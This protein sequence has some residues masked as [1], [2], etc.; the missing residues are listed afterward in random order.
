MSEAELPKAIETA[1][2]E[3]VET[4]AEPAQGKRASNGLAWLALLIAA[5]SAGAVSWQYWQ[6]QQVTQTVSADNAQVLE[7]QQ[8]LTAL[9]S[10]QHK[11]QQQI[12]QLQAKTADE[13]ELQQALTSVQGQQQR[14]AQQLD[15]LQNDG[16]N[17]LRLAEA[18][19]LLRLAALRLSA[20]QDVS[21]AKALLS[22][23]DGLL[24]E[25]NDPTA[26]AARRELANVLEALHSRPAPDRTGLYLSL[27]A[28]GQELQRLTVEPPSFVAQQPAVVAGQE[29]SHWQEWWQ[30]LSGFVRIEFNTDQDIRPLLA[31]QQ[32]AQVRLALSLAIEQ[33]QWAVL[34][35]EQQVYQQ[36]LKQAEE[37]L[38]GQFAESAQVQAL[39]SR[40]S[41]LAKQSLSYEVPDMTAALQAFSAYLQSRQNQTGE[42]EVSQ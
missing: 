40:L 25:Q 24:R 9:Q 42:H 28:L 32:L 33:A 4:P 6:A 17:E 21:S 16:R 35:G 20:L 11:W 13:A 8:Q 22:G 5:A 1:V 37:I 12:E 7:L 18:E 41:E 31:G 3:V 10:Q 23:A 14:Q 2:D 15:R 29:V 38:R 36:A 30:K 26:F 34:N 19:H 39:V 27:A